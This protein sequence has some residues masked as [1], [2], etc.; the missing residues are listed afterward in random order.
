MSGPFEQKR[1][2]LGVT[3]SIALY[4]AVDLASKLTHSGAQVDVLMTPSAQEFVSALTF[5]SITHRPVLTDVFDAA[6]PNAVE[7]VALAKAA[8]IMIIAPA[9]ANTIAKLAWGFADD[10]V[11]LTALATEAPI[12][13]APAMDAAM[14]TKK[15]VM[16]N[17]DTLRSQ[18]MHIAGP[19]KGHLAS[20]LEG[21][22]RMLEVPELLGHIA[23]ILG[24]KRDLANRRVVVS[25]GGTQEPIDPVRVL[26][27]RSSGKMGYAI[28]EAARDRGALVHLISTTKT[29]PDPVGVRVVRVETYE[30]MR[31]AVLEACSEADVLIM[32][33]AVADFSP[34]EVSV[35]KQ[36]KEKATNSELLLRLAKNP[37]FFHEV[38]EGV[39]R[40]GFA[41]E[42]ENLLENARKKLAEKD[43]ALIAVNDITRD[44][45][46]FGAD[47]NQ[48]T[49]LDRE[50]VAQA[51]PLLPKYEVAVRLLER[52]R[53]LLDVQPCRPRPLP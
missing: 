23:L 52:V 35:Q 29:L 31:E 11:S 17:A 42:S 39:L 24:R 38:R 7:H 41:A 25:A 32:A 1:I 30:E 16:D 51:L 21:W 37:D 27:N 43:L 33:A 26:T 34:A 9:T 48:V 6:S 13:I 20:G 3:G 12:L 22:G 45:S 28:A 19:A 5:R 10:P 4:K 44:D 36:K 47:D 18:G 46:G 40:V 2:I 53:D 14:W 49:I 8:D 50:G 15:P